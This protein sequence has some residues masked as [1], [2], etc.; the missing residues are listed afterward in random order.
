MRPIEMGFRRSRAV[1]PVRIAP[2]TEHLPF[3]Q[4]PP[5]ARARSRPFTYLDTKRAFPLSRCELGT[6]FFVKTAFLRQ[7]TGAS[8]WPGAAIAP[9]LRAVE[10]RI[11]DLLR[12]REPLLTEIASYLVHSGGKRVRPAV[13]LLVFR[14]CGGQD[15]KAVIDAAAALEMIHSATLLHDDIIDGSDTRRGQVSALRRFG[16]ANTLVTGDFLFSRAFQICGEFEK[17]LIR[18]AAEACISLTEGEILQGRFRRNPGVTVRDYFEIISRKTASLFATGARSG[19]YLARASQAVI[20]AMSECGF[21]VG[22]VFQMVDDLLDIE[23]VQGRIGKPVGID[24]RDGNPSLPLVLAVQRDPEV[25]R[26]FQSEALSPSDI[27]GAL[28]RIRASSIPHEVRQ[29]ALEH[30]ALAQRALQC[31]PES[32]YREHLA[33]LIDQLVYRPA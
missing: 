32:E 1:P 19:A 27:D 31:L 4:E 21:E 5:S 14:A 6:G 15:P 29:M 7:G 22:L 10:E 30:A 9:E 17:I 12:S 20:G 24:L 2:G 23:G 3:G 8:L 26:L 25:R 16:I 18:W 33:H 28:V 11:D 13:T